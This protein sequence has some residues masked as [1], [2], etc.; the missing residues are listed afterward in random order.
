MIS[1]GVF[2]ED[3]VSGFRGTITSRVENLSGHVRYE[4]TPRWVP[5][6]PLESDWFDEHS[7]C[8]YTSEEYEKLCASIPS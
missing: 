4:I 2:A 7:I 1:L 8:V 3:T 6:K 5:G